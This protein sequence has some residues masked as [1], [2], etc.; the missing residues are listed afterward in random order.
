MKTEQNSYPRSSSIEDLVSEAVDL[1]DTRFEKPANIHGLS[2]GDDDIDLKSSGV[3]LDGLTVIAGKTAS[4]CQQFVLQTIIQQSCSDNK[5]ISSINLTLPTFHHTAELLSHFG[6]ISLNDI[7]R[8]DISDALW[9]GLTLAINKLHEA[10]IY[11]YTDVAI[12]ISSLCNEITVMHRKSGINIFFINDLS[13]INSKAKKN[14]HLLK[15]TA[16]KN[17]ISIILNYHVSSVKKL[18]RSEI[19]KYSDLVIFLKNKHSHHKVTFLKN[20][21]ISKPVFFIT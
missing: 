13:Q 19:F 6:G 10:E 8:G 12:S 21:S 7:L 11:V 20:I 17:N 4:V 2:F 14:A 1:I 16:R 18:C 9:P 5:R 15:K 3:P